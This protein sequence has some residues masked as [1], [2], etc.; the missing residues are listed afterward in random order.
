MKHTISVLVENQFGVLARVAGL[1]SGRGFNI[2]SL[3]VA[4]TMD[5]T[6]SRMTIVTSGH[7]GIIEQIEKQL[8]KLINVIKVH[9][10]TAESHIEREM[11]LVKVNAEATNR[12]EILRIVDIFRAKVVDVTPRTYTIEITGDEDKLEAFLKLLK[13]IGIRE[14]VRTGKVAMARGG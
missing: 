4:E 2:E 5:P 11:V 1:F 12:A 7:D 3:N 14:I 9:D 6:V 8:N 10:L 13:P